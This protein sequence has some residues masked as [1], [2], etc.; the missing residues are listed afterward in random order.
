MQ[1][2]LCISKMIRWRN[3]GTA[4]SVASK[5]SEQQSARAIPAD[6]DDRVPC[7]HDTLVYVHPGGKQK[8]KRAK[9]S[10]L[11]TVPAAPTSA[12]H[13]VWLTKHDLIAKLAVVAI[14]GC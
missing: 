9:F 7:S 4:S 13:W 5:T 10:S 3:R 6:V 8:G 14:S 11:A 1:L 2:T 12:S